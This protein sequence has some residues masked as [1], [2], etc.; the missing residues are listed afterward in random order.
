MIGD[1]C[2]ETERLVLRPFKEGD[3]K[4]VL[5]LMSDAYICRMA[6]IKPFKTIDEAK[7]FMAYWDGEIFAMTEKGGDKVIGIIQ[8]PCLWWRDA[9]GL[10]YWLA[11]EYRGR[12]YMTEAIEAVKKRLFENWWCDEILLYVFVGNEASRNV[13]LKCGFRL[14]YE[15]YKESIYS[16]YGRVESEECFSITR[17]DY[18]WEQRGEDF[19]S[20]AA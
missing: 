13:A 3:A 2:I 9:M 19:Y 16:P 11:A 20:T 5:A 15:S 6:G 14:K 17:G 18:E 1:D 4:E 8:T 12:G 7:V 10:G